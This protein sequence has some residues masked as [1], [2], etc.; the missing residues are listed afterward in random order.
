[1]IR[2][3]RVAALAFLL[4]PA[5]A[6]AQSGLTYDFTLAEMVNGQPQSSNGHA[7]VLGNNVRMDIVGSSSLGSFNQMSL[8][9]SVTVISADTGMAQLV[10][11][12]GHKDKTY[13][14]FAPQVMMK[15]MRDMMS[16]M[17]GMSQMSFTGSQVTVDSIGSGGMIAGYNTI[18]Y[19]LTIAMKI[20]VGGQPMGDQ[21]SVMDT[22][23]APDLKEFAQ[24]SSM[25]GGTE[26]AATMPGIPKT[27]TD[28]LT[29]AGKRVGYAMALKTEI[30]ASGSM[31]GTSMS[32]KQV[33]EVTAV[34]RADVPAAS[35]VVPA[36]YKKVVPPGMESL[37]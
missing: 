26:E 10:S 9:D 12:V 4:S 1:M 35:F 6:L 27:L 8:G 32:R 20:G 37:M 28:Q 34:K 22:Y 5:A 19:R 15:K 21:S 31:M 16:G 14:Q 13:V 3:V 18:H 29:A 24:G 7:M 30:T 23:V 33:L 11:L 2:L 17:P 36:G 25:L